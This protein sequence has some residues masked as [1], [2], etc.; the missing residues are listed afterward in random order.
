MS[1]PGS[2][3]LSRVLN[4]GFRRYVRRFI[5][6]NFNA[7]RVTGVEHLLSLGEGPVLIYVNHPGWWDPMSAVLVTDLLMS[8]R[9]FAAPMDADALKRYPILERLGFFGV[10]RDSTAGAREFLR[11][12]RTVLQDSR[13]A[14]WM[15]PTGRFHDVRQAL[16]FQPGLAH[17]VDSDFAG[18]VLPV[19][20]EYP[21]W[22]ERRPELLVACGPPV[23][24][25]QL[26]ADRESRTRQLEAALLEVQTHLR[27]L[28]I[29]RDPRSFRLLL[30]GQGGIGGWYGLWRRLSF[31][32]RGQK[33]ADRHEE[34][35][36]D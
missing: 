10:S 20:L 5:G 35:S 15:T 32:R 8:E 34:R 14:L 11:T 3:L 30:D 13:T 9:Q 26:S 31:W 25:S 6:S 7:A 33:F 12:A 28:A 21:F 24:C 2:G 36:D 1:G 18:M 22:N 4:R 23:N 17:L 19:A 16:P 27:D 29:A